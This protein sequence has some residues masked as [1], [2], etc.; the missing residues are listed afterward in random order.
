M[1]MKGV[2]SRLP[3]MDNNELTR[4]CF[5]KI[6]KSYACHLRTYLEIMPYFSEMIELS[7]SHIKR[8]FREALFIVVERPFAKS[9]RAYGDT[10]SLRLLDY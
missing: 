5:L 7:Q 10:L 1:A 2:M 9:I 6:A 4:L 8:Y 3:F